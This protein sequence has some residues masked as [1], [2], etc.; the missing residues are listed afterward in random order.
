M[1]A[2]TPKTFVSYTARSVS[3]VVSL[4]RA[5]PSARTMPA[6]L[7]LAVSPRFAEMWAA[8]DVEVRRRI[9]KRVNHPVAGPLEFDC[10]VLHVPDSDQ[11]L[12]VYCAAPGSPTRA[13]FRR[14]AEESS[15]RAPRTAEVGQAP[16]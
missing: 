7:L 8:H 13:A 5:L 4:G 14:L 12:I 10:Q 1:T 11:R 15:A 16:A 6:L 9:V 3:S 2:T